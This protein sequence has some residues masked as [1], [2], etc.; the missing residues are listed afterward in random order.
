M[1]HPDHD[2]ALDWARYMTTQFK[3]VSGSD[4]ALQNV[5]RAYLSLAAETK[6]LWAVKRAGKDLA[7]LLRELESHAD[8]GMIEGHATPIVALKNLEQALAAAGDDDA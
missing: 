2:A 7:E 8:A 3:P 5:A 4:Y 1:T 6:K